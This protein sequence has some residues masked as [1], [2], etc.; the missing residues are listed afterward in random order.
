MHL[1]KDARLSPNGHEAAR[2]RPGLIA[3]I[4]QAFCA[5][6]RIAWSAPWIEERR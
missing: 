2:N 4:M 1:S 6:H 5:L 3:A